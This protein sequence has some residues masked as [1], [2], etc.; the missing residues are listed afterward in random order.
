MRLRLL[1]LAARALR[2]RR[3]HPIH[4]QIH[5]DHSHLGISNDAAAAQI[6]VPKRACSR[7]HAHHAGASL[8]RKDAPSRALDARSLVA[9]LRRVVA[10]L[11]NDA[12]RWCSCCGGGHCR[13]G[14]HGARVARVRE[15]DAALAG[16]HD[17]DGSRGAG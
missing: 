1:L 7:E 10:R 9:P 13:R 11:G 16:P 2:R 15:V 8:V 4:G 6:R 12:G 17:G 14:Y 3:H 5:L